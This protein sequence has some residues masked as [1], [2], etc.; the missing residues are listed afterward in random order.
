MLAVVFFQFMQTLLPPIVMCSPSF[1]KLSM[2]SWNIHGLGDV[3]KCVLVRNSFVA[4]N[5]MFACV[6]EAKLS[7]VDQRKISSFLPSRLSAFAVKDA[8]GSRGGILMAWDPSMFFLVSSSVSHFS[9][10]TSVSSVAAGFTLTI[11][12]VYAPSDHSLTDDFV[13]DMLTLPPLASGPWLVVGDFNLIRFPWE[14]NNENFNAGHA[15]T[16]N[17]LINAFA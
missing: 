8:D 17:A 5:P 11:T 3:D 6:Q 13:T 10:T 14:K 15:A 1:K 9:L 12:S 7:T 2:L 4:A 16:F